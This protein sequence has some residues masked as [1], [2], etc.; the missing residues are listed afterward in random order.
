MYKEINELIM[1]FPSPLTLNKVIHQILTIK[2]KN[3]YKIEYMFMMFIIMTI[4]GLVHVIYSGISLTGTSRGP[5]GKFQ[6]LRVS[7]IENN[8]I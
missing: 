7:V 4:A 8:E 5:H 1:V 6:L 2:L 3:R